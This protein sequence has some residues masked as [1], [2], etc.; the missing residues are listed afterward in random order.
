M[1]AEIIHDHDIAGSKR[2]DENLLDVSEE[3]AAVD[4]AV[5]NARG[6]DLVGAQRGNESQGSPVTVGHFRDKPFAA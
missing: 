6:R 1:A 4:R 2:F 5:E 3:A